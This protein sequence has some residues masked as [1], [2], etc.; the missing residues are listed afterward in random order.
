M[1][2]KGATIRINQELNVKDFM[3]LNVTQL[4]APQKFAGTRRQFD[5]WRCRQ[6]SLC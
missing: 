6:Q 1:T 3:R 2:P 4:A 5:Q